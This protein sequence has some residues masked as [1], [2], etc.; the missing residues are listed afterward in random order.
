MKAKSPQADTFLGIAFA[1]LGVFFIIQGFNLVGIAR[2]T[3]I[4]CGVIDF[5]LAYVRLKHLWIKK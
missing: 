1:I 4:V 3:F 5:I 2:I